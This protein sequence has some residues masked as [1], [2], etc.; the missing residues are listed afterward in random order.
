MGTLIQNNQAVSLARPRFPA[1]REVRLKIG[2]Y[3]FKQGNFDQAAKWL[4]AT[5]PMN[6]ITIKTTNEDVSPTLLGRNRRTKP[7]FSRIIGDH[8]ASGVHS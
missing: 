4:D 6:A 1:L 5:N 2:D 7:E 3:Y 8:K